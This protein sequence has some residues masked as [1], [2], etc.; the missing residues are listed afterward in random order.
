MPPSGIILFGDLKIAASSS[1]SSRFKADASQRQA[2]VQGSAIRKGYL[3]S[4][5][6]ALC[7]CAGLSSHVQVLC[8][9]ASPMRA[10]RQQRAL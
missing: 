2:A 9:A 6:A 10:Q 1:S 3:H 5:R 7:H 4:G 8:K